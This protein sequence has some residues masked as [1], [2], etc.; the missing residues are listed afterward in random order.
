MAAGSSSILV[1]ILPSMSAQALVRQTLSKLGFFGI[2]TLHFEAQSIELVIVPIVG[3]YMPPMLPMNIRLL[4]MKWM[5]LFYKY[6]QLKS[7][8]VLEPNSGRMDRSPATETI[9]AGS[10][11]VRVK[12][13]TRK[14]GI[15]SFPA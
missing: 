8:P 4:R 6:H 7:T 15:H 1:L 2:M 12:P 5:M 9:D 14:I 11:P 3:M 10:S 13:K